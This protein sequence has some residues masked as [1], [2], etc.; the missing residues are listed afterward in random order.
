M[1]TSAC[2]SGSVASFSARGPGQDGVTKPNISAPGVNVRSSLPGGTYG[3]IN[4]TSMASPHVAGAVALAWSGAPS[5]IGDIAG[6]RALLDETA[7]DTSDLT[8]GGTAA[9]NNVWGQGKLDAQESEEAR[10]K[11]RARDE[12]GEGA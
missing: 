7:V 12:E 8:C 4:G 1:K 2:W 9:N 5:L 6:T 10:R 3:S 11:R